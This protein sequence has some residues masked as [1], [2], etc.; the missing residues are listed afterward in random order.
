MTLQPPVFKL[1][2]NINQLRLG[3]LIRADCFLVKKQAESLVSAKSLSLFLS[4]L[5]QKSSTPNFTLHF[6]LNALD[7]ILYLNWNFN[8]KLQLQFSIWVFN[9]IL[10]LPTLTVTSSLNFKNQLQ[11][12]NWIFNVKRHLHLQTLTLNIKIKVN[13]RVNF[14]CQ[15]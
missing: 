12:L 13:F 11:N 4:W 1:I 15:F 14:Q 8:Y 5:W 2:F 3:R 7:S 6:Y 10:L 9:F